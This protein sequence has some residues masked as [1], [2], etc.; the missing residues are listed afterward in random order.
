M[1]R[2]IQ[3]F[4]TQLTAD[5]RNQQPYNPG[6]GQHAPDNHSRDTKP[7]LHLS[8]LIPAR[9]RFYATSSFRPRRPRS[10]PRR[11]S[12]PDIDNHSTQN[13]TRRLGPVR[14]IGRIGLILAEPALSQNAGENLGAPRRTTPGLFP[15][16]HRPIRKRYAEGIRIYCA[17][18]AD[19]RETWMAHDAA[20]RVRRALI[21]RAEFAEKPDVALVACHP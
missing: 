11:R 18:T 1:E 16:E 15:V 14:P 20:Y 2:L 8:F 3:R 7:N 13:G 12:V 21:R 5:R 6:R 10:R 4:V 9:G 19:D 17:P